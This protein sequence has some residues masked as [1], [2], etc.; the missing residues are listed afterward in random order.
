MAGRVI[1]T[2]SPIS[3]IALFLGLTTSHEYIGQPLILLFVQNE[4]AAGF[5]MILVNAF[6]SVVAS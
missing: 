2:L 4:K 1:V 5:I 6:T 3:S